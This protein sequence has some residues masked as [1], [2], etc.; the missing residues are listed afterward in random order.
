MELEIIGLSIVFIQQLLSI[1]SG[2]IEYSNRKIKS[3]KKSYLKGNQHTLC[4]ETRNKSC[5]RRGNIFWSVYVWVCGMM[6]NSINFPWWLPRQ[7]IQP[8]V[9]PTAGPLTHNQDY[10]WSHTQLGIRC[11]ARLY[12]RMSINYDPRLGLGDEIYHELLLVYYAFSS[13]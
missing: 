7:S 3:M 4:Y 9:G 6:I 12:V 13:F 10:L 2:I 1:L 5:G 11:E 8:W